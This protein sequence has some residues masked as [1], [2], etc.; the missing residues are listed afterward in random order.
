MK[1]PVC[2]TSELVGK[3]KYCSGACRVKAS[4]TKTEPSTQSEP[5]KTK[6]HWVGRAPHRATWTE[7]TRE[8]CAHENNSEPNWEV[9]CAKACCIALMV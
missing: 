3:Q 7:C 5:E 1:C 9:T 8:N 6:G 4:R 2:N